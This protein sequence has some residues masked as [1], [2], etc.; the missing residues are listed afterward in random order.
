MV[1]ESGALRAGSNDKGETMNKFEFRYAEVSLDTVL[2]A[3]ANSYSVTDGE[4]KGVQYFVDPFKDKVI[5]KLIVEVSTA[6]EDEG[7]ES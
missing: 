4:L 6:S 2:R 5:F 3:F 7:K 1:R